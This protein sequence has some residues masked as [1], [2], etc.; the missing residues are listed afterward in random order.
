MFRCHLSSNCCRQCSIDCDT[1]MYYLLRGENISLMGYPS[2][3]QGRQQHIQPG[4]NWGLPGRW[5]KNQAK[6]KV[7]RM[8]SSMKQPDYWNQVRI[9]RIK[10]LKSW[11]FTQIH[12]FCLEFL[13]FI[14][15]KLVMIFNQVQKKLRSLSNRSQIWIYNKLH[16]YNFVSVKK[17]RL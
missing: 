10:K 8:K 11:S 9:S 16:E 2:H 4:G 1:R 12:D 3:G 6:R 17:L 5:P 14:Y 13:H 7:N 15:K